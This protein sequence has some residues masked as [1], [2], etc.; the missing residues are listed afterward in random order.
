MLER[1]YPN[2]YI[3]SLASISMDTFSKKDIRGII[4]DLDK[5]ITKWNQND[6]QPDVRLWLELLQAE[7]IS[8]CILSN[9]GKERVEPVAAD[10]GIPYVF[11]AGKPKHKGY[12]HAIKLLDTHQKN[13]AVIGDQIFTDIWGGNR[14][15]LFT[16]LVK[17]LEGPEFPGTKISRFFERRLFKIMMKSNAVD[18]RI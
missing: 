5:T 17:P 16:I 11:K 8:A 18:I 12:L 4:L 15:G 9:N 10:L 3:N 1:F 7:Q 6:I 13:T 14:L 2:M